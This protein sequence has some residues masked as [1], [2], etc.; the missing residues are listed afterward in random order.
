MN[1]SQWM[2]SEVDEPRACNIQSEANQKEKN[3]YR[4]LT[5]MYGI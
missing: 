1:L 4:V 2:S 3:K 5:H